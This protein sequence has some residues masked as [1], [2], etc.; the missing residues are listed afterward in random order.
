MN[1]NN[2]KTQSIAL[3]TGATSGIGRAI[4]VRLLEDGYRVFGIGRNPAGAPVHDNFRL[5]AVD[6]T[7]ADALTAAMRELPC[8][9]S[10]LVNAAGVAFYG[11]HETIAPRNIRSMIDVNVTAPI[12]L[13]SVLLPQLKENAGTILNVSSVTAKQNANTHGCAYG[14]TKAALTV[15]SESL[16][17]ECRKYGLRVITLHPDLTDTAL[18]RNAD[19]AP[20]DEPDCR[21]TADEVADYA[22]IALHAREGMDVTDITIRPQKNKI[23]RRTDR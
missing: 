22:M 13:T 6:L 12:I 9:V 2:S 17:A 3:V 11:P 16:F 10:V 5:L 19:F 23:V 14:A 1:D 4:T 18:Y 21:L 8:P 7:D 15:F 20:A